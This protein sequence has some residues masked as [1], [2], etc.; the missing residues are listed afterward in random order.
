[1]YAGY[2]ESNSLKSDRKFQAAHQKPT[3]GESKSDLLSRMNIPQFRPLRTPIIEMEKVF[4]ELKFDNQPG[5]AWKQGFEVSYNMSQWDDKP[6]EVFL[7]PHSHQDPGWIFTIDEYFEKKT[8][9]GLDATLEVLLRH[10]EARFIYAEMSFFSKWINGLSPDAKSSVSKLLHNGQL[11]IA[12]GGW[13]MPDEATASYYAI[14]D[15]M[16]EGHHW[17]WENFAYRPNISWSIDP[18]GQSTTMAYL[19]RKMG[20]TGMVIGRVH[21]EVKKY[22]ARRKALEFHWGQSWDPQNQ[23]QIPCHLLAFYAYDVPH[24][25]GPDP[26]VCCQFDFWRLKQ[27]TCP[28][29]KPPQ[30]INPDNEEERTALLVDQYRKKATLYNQPDVLLVPLGDDFRFLSTAEW[31]LQLENYNRIIKVLDRHPEYR[32]K[33][34]FA[35]LSEYFEAFYRRHGFEPRSAAQPIAGP[36]RLNL[37]LLIGDLFTYADRNQDYW[38]GYFTSRPVEKFITR[39]LESELRASEILYTFARFVIQRFPNSQLN[40][41]IR[42]LDDRLTESRR[43]LGLFQHHD[44]VTGTAKSHVAADYNKRLI[45][46][47]VHSRLVSSISTFVLLN[48]LPNPDVVSVQGPMV[49]EQVYDIIRLWS[50]TP[51]ESTIMSIEDLYSN[52][53]APV[54]SKITLD[55]PD[56]PISIVVFNPLPHA[57]TTTITVH[58]DGANEHYEVDFA[59]PASESEDRPITIQMEPLDSIAGSTTRLRIGPVYLVPLSLSQVVLKPTKT[60]SDQSV[61]ISRGHSVSDGFTHGSRL[62]WL[63][64]DSIQLGFNA[65]TG[66]LQYLVDTRLTLAVNIA[67][68]FL[69]YKTF[70]RSESTSGA[71]LFIPSSPGQVMELPTNPKIR[72]TRGPLVE[73]ITLDTPMVRHTVRLHKYPNSI[74]IENTVNLNNVQPPNIELAMRI[75]SNVTNSDRVFYTD[76]NCFQFVRRQYYDKIPF[77]GNLYPMSCGV[78]IQSES[79][80]IHPWMLRLHLFSTYSHGVTSP[81]PG[82][83]Y[84]FLDRRTAQDDN[85]GLNEPLNGQW[86]AQSNF[87]LFV[88]SVSPELGAQ[89]RNTP[90]LSL[91]AHASLTDL[92]RPIQRFEMHFPTALYLARVVQLT[93]NFALPPEYDLVSLKTFNHRTELFK[94]YS[95]PHGAQVGMILRRLPVTSGLETNYLIS[96]VHMFP[97]IERTTAVRTSL[98]LMPEVSA[99]QFSQRRSHVVHVRPMELEAYLLTP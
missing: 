33:L 68:D 80:T 81:D 6:L 73:E 45:S 2:R 74:E 12:S 34:R 22:L 78:Y 63:D 90:A 69:I 59:P 87:R 11:E 84:V 97:R 48:V 3:T 15:Q 64:S 7:V 56:L 50:K 27:G 1:M 9:A 53:A 25:C 85:R 23:A 66:L 4:Q 76:S 61:R 40:E 67:I 39:T 75:Q 57:R 86:I 5:G 30:P 98:T 52:S 8:H 47:L 83:L 91:E 29:N 96:I 55:S 43:A 72:V 16:I 49:P 58:V 71:Y 79:S 37:S 13:V 21:Y 62:I 17:L 94:P 42:L 51:D 14:V 95:D 31:A 36:E 35:T 46:A 88:E 32:V 99:N 20:F 44:G 19:V 18:F 54:P 93:P 41:T 10:P 82:S 60:P 89:Q 65:R 28:W 77:Q 38:S 24:T 26:A 92:V 70:D